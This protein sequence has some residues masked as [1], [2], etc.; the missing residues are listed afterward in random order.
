M[1]NTE[2]TPLASIAVPVV[3]ATDKA[4]PPVLSIYKP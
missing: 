4:I 2:L 1:L 3:L